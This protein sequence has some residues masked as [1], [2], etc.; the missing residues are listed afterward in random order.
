MINNAPTINRT[1]LCIFLRN[2]KRHIDYYSTLSEEQKNNSL[3][4][5]IIDSYSKEDSP[6]QLGYYKRWNSIIPLN[7]ESLQL[8]PKDLLKNK[9]VAKKIIENNPS[10]YKFLETNLKLD[11]EL[12]KF[13]F[14][15]MK[16][17]TKRL[18]IDDID[19][20]FPGFLTNEDI[21]LKVCTIAIHCTRIKN[22]FDTL[23]FPLIPLSFTKNKQ[24]IKQLLAEDYSLYKYIPLDL[25]EDFDIM[26]DSMKISHGNVFCYFHPDL[27]GDLFF[28]HYMSKF[29]EIYGN[30]LSGD[31]KKQY[32]QTNGSSTNSFL[33]S[34][35]LKETLDEKLH[36]KL[37]TKEK[38]NKI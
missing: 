22:N 28:S 34:L 6:S 10:L 24:F 1:K 31:L 15:T 8:L 26:I 29:G 9:I 17:E 11:D 2:V 21:C 32:L 12:I 7:E 37:L 5:A 36:H 25:K 23:F 30:Y 35:M 33:N 20:Y 16:T 27:R 19:S 13:L 18:I 4:K 3:K 38:T 14:D